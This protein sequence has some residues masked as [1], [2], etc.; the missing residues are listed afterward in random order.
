MILVLSYRVVV[1]SSIPFHLAVLYG[2]SFIALLIAI[3]AH[4]HL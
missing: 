3:M 2:V 4:W 1:G